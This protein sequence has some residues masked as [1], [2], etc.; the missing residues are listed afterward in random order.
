MICEYCDTITLKPWNFRL[1]NTMAHALEMTARKRVDRLSR[2]TASPRWKAM[3]S[4][5]S[6][7]RTR[8]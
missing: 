4:E 3:P 7:N 6:R 5:F 8:A 1:R 2:S